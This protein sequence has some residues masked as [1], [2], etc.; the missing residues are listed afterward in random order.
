M[1]QYLQRRRIRFRGFLVLI[2]A[3]LLS[4]PL[5][6]HVKWFSKYSFYDQPYQLGDVTRPTLF[7]ILL[8]AST[9]VVGL[10]SLL[11]Q[12]IE[13]VGWYQNAITWL[14]KYQEKDVLLMRAA[15]AAVL[16][17]SWQVGTLMMPELAVASK[18]I[19]GFQF[20]LAVLLLFRVMVPWVGPGLWGLYL[21]GV[22]QF[23][24]FHM[25][26]YFLLVGV[27]YFFFV[28]NSDKPRLRATG[29]FMLYATL[30]FSLC[31]AGLEKLIYP[32][33]GIYILEHHPQLTLG[34]GK[35]LFVQ[36]AAFIE[37]SVGVM[38]IFC[39]LY[40]I[41]AVIVTLL[42]ILTTLVFGKT[43][44]I[45]HLLIHVALIIFLLQ[46]SGNIFQALPAFYRRIGRNPFLAGLGFVI[47]FFG[48]LAAYSA[49]ANYKY[50]T[51]VKG[52]TE[53]HPH[54]VEITD[55]A[56]VP[57]VSI[58]AEAASLGGWNLYLQTSN[59][60]FLSPDEL[61]PTIGTS[62]YAGLSIDGVE[63]TRLYDS[64]YYLPPRAAGI[65]QVEVVLYA[66]NQARFAHLGMP[67]ADSYELVVKN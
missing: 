45:G 23:G 33:W 15:V 62:G 48:F 18:W 57:S 21:M 20:L 3:I 31:W 8:L 64:W 61:P 63:I 1:L 30:G 47:L 11:H 55:E 26:D 49:A 38:L 37:I 13:K 29:L 40:R 59:F 43:E 2:L 35:A 25:L 34:L 5:H 19:G 65:Y 56:Q 17:V 36:G 12:R 67:I 28:S 32:Q 22:N 4:Q 52:G 39:F 51:N 41:L 42:F 10:F 50:E 60:T 6:A 7:W 54:Q 46:G 9:V 27:G 66:S 58:Q 14:E 53:A 24:I 16:L 44:I